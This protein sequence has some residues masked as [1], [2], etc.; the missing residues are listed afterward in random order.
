MCFTPALLLFLFALIAIAGVQA[1]NSVSIEQ[2]RG[3]T[4][5]VS[6]SLRESPENCVDTN[7]ETRCCTAFSVSHRADVSYRASIHGNGVLNVSTLTACRVDV[8]GNAWL[9]HKLGPFRTVGSGSGVKVEIYD[10]AR[11][12]DRSLDLRKGLH[13][14]GYQMRP[15]DAAGEVIIF[16]PLHEHHVHVGVSPCGVKEP[17]ADTQMLSK[18]GDFSEYTRA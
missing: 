10:L 18:N 8:A 16:P 7:N 2:T 14:T 4:P 6:S 12:A 15:V 1:Q 11:W 3:Q 13:L 9:T 5:P 17:P